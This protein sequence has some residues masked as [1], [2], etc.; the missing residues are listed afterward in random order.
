MNDSPRPV[1]SGDKGDCTTER[2]RTSTTEVHTR[3]PG[4]QKRTTEEA[5]AN[6]KSLTNDGK[7]KK[8]SPNE[9]KGG[10][11][12]KM[13]NKIEA[14]QL[15]DIEFKAMVIKKLNELT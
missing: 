11:S 13:L 9:G 4:S 5:E 8:Q 14:S 6:K 7:K 2:H 1:S 15:S 12:E 10:A 3:N